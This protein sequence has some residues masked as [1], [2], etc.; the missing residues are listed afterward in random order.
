MEKYTVAVTV[1]TERLRN[2]GYRDHARQELNHKAY[3]EIMKIL[4][5]GQ[6][7][8]LR[9]TYNEQRE[10][11]DGSTFA[12]FPDQ[13]TYFLILE[14]GTVQIQQYDIRMPNDAQTP[15]WQVARNAIDE[16]KYR[17]RARWRN[18]WGAKK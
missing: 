13:T 4:G 7:H 2:Q 11:S 10:W 17:I 16:L 18:F 14:V 3:D 12:G 9:I 5:D 6:R 1:D 15:T 8:L